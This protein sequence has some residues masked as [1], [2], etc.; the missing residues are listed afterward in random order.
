MLSIGGGKGARR[1]YNMNFY[2]YPTDAPPTKILSKLRHNLANETKDIAM[3]DV[4]NATLAAHPHLR[5][6]VVFF[7]SSCGEARDLTRNQ[8]DEI[9]TAQQRARLKFLSYTPIAR[10]GPFEAPARAV[11]NRLSTRLTSESFHP[12]AYGSLPNNAMRAET[13]ASRQFGQARRTRRRKRTRSRKNK[14]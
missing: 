1:I 11:G 5:N 3:S 13:P 10:G 8:I 9:A 12:S 7:F 4:I 6:G 14:F 2:S